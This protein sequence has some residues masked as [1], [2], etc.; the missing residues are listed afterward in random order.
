MQSLSVAVLLA[1]LLLA[2]LGG[3]GAY[4]FWLE[5]LERKR[6]EQLNEKISALEKSE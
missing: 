2:G 6:S 3:W 4:H 1:G 5:I